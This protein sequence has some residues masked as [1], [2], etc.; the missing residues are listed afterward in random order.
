M[1]PIPHVVLQEDHV[2]HCVNKH[3]V[4]EQGLVLHGSS[5]R[6]S[7]IVP[8]QKLFIEGTIPHTHVLILYVVPP[9][10]VASQALHEDQEDQ[11]QGGGG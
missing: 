10:Q 4:V 9:P 7:D 5:I 3:V 6:L 1:V 8:L 2:D 11:A